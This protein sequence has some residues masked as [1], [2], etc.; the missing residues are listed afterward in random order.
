MV[1][2][3]NRKRRNKMDKMSVAEL[4][5]KGFDC[6]Q[7]VLAECAG[8]LGITREE[9]CRMS[10][11]FGGGMG[12]GETC[13]AVVGAMIALGLKYGHCREDAMEQK[14]VM[15]RKRAEFIEAFRG[16]YGSCACRDLLGHDISVPGEFDKVLEEG[17]LFD[18]C[19]QVVCDTLEI[20]EKI[21]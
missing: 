15:N 17:L 14:D 1:P 8:D 16:K 9:A 10:A 21:L 13:G 20:L 3:G 18:F 5:M 11:A 2:E 7:V 4:F 6:S 19:P 12:V